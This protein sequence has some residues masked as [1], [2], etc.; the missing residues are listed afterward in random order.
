MLHKRFRLVEE[1]SAVTLQRDDLPVGQC[2][3]HAEG[4]G[5]APSQCVAFR[6]SDLAA[7]SIRQASVGCRSWNTASRAPARSP[8]PCRA[9]SPARSPRAPSVTGLLSKCARN[10]SSRDCCTLPLNA[11]TAA[12]LVARILAIRSFVTIAVQRI[13]QITDGR[14]HLRE[15]GSGPARPIVRAPSG[16]G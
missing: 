1:E 7:C 11:E 12:S 4:R 2:E 16:R 3:V 6:A 14:A 10:A 13:G 5:D 8:H 15:D 9:P